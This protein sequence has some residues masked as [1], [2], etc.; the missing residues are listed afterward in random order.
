MSDFS[1]FSD[2]ENEKKKY[3][4][5]T[6]PNE[7]YYEKTE[8]PSLKIKKKNSNSVPVSNSSSS[9]SI[10][11]FTTPNSPKDENISIE[12]FD[13]LNPKKFTDQF[14]KQAL[15]NLGLTY[16]DISYPTKEQM[17]K[18][19]LDKSLYNIIFEKL[20][21]RTNKSIE[22]IK[23]ERNRI[24]NS[25]NK[26]NNKF[27]SNNK[28]QNFNE[29]EKKRLNKLEIYKKKHAEQIIYSMLLEH[30]NLKQ[31]EEFKIFEENKKKKLKK[32]LKI[33]I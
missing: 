13:P 20:I 12:N 6:N 29:L 23:N 25:N 32:K 15:K 4:F 22:F 5:E 31:I 21:K 16:I 26:L 14:S 8:L 19:T 17:E 1:D 24:I 10:K 9:T 33:K 30:E 28:S 18:Y 2:D 7:N 3:L 11:Y 27:Y